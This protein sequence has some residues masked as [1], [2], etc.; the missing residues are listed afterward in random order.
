[1]SI[2]ISDLQIEVEDA[3]NSVATA[4][5]QEFS[6]IEVLVQGPQGPPGPEGPE[7]EPLVLP[8]VNL[9][10]AATIAV[11]ALLGS[12]MRVT[13][14]G[15]RTLGNPTNPQDGQMIM[16]EIK[17]DGTGSRTLALA[18]KYNFGSDLTSIVLSTLP[19]LTD[20]LLVMYV[21]ARDE[22]DIIGF[23]KGF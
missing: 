17:Q 2:L 18:S 19:G 22:W 14:G 7:G 3:V 9:T 10:D 13:L 12:L 1:M 4:I 11:D 15:N 16:F 20:R 5:G 21:L 8:P 23:K 6:L